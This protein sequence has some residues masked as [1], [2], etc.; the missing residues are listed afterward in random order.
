MTGV[1]VA[2]T[3]TATWTLIRFHKNQ[4]SL[5]KKVS[6]LTVI[7]V[8]KNGKKYAKGQFS[9][10]FDKIDFLAKIDLIYKK[11]V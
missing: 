10:I 3:F 4:H 7:R 8:E 9:T 1:D 6:L 5:K 11:F 2:Y